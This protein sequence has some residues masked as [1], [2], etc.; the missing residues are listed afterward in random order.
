MQ[1][2]IRADMSLFHL[3]GINSP[4]AMIKECTVNFIF[5]AEFIDAEEFLPIN[6]SSSIN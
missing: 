1:S 3:G 4:T 6:E 5:D 2:N